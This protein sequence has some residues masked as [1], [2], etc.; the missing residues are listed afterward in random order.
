MEN[1]MA[2]DVAHG[3]AWKMKQ[4]EEK[5]PF[6]KNSFAFPSCKMSTSDILRYV[7]GK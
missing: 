7:L 6:L 3:L 4:S 1:G 5:R 2:R